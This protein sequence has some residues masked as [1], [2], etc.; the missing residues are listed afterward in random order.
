MFQLEAKLSLVTL[1]KVGEELVIC[2]KYVYAYLCI[3]IYVCVCVC[4]CV[5]VWLHGCRCVYVNLCLS[6]AVL[7]IAPGKN[8]SFPSISSF[9]LGNAK[10]DGVILGELLYW[11][12]L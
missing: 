7:F 10:F 3:Y 8:A 11:R 6:M 2:P 4:V 12:P 9:S 5:C 1:A